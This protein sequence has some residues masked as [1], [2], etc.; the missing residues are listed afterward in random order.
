M[1]KNEQQYQITLDWLR[2]FERTLAKLDSDENLKA[3]DPMSWQMYRNSYQRQ[4]D[5]F[6]YEIAEYE[7]LID[8]D[9][10]HDLQIEVKSLTHLP[11]ALI[12]ARMAAKI[13]QEK[14]AETLGISSQRVKEY[15]DTDYQC[16]SFVEL[17]EVSTA[18][19][20]EVEKAVMRVDFEEIEEVAQIA[21]E[22]QEKKRKKA[23]AARR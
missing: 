11:W 12:K 3:N 7:R 22:R 15:E 18:L 6:K 13:S 4:V 23:M 8:C 5:E 19:G 2:R 21:K 17:L 20:V 10:K 1:I 16:A 9:R 14:L